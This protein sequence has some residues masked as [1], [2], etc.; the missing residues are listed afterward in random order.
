MFVLLQ[1]EAFKVDRIIYP[2]MCTNCPCID[3][4]IRGAYHCEGHEF[5]IVTLAGGEYYSRNTGSLHRG[6]KT[7][8]HGGWPQL[9]DD[10][11]TRRSKCREYTDLDAERTKVGEPTK[12]IGSDEESAVREGV[13][14]M[15]HR[16]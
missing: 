10:F 15:P 11:T 13:R 7:A 12:G 2:A 3:P 9:R 8:N 1:H 14:A 16:R 4:A 5:L 6:D